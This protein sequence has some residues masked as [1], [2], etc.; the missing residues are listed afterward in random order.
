MKKENKNKYAYINTK[1]FAT[2]GSNMPKQLELEEKI[3]EGEKKEKIEKELGERI[4]KWYESYNNC[5]PWS[6]V[7]GFIVRELKTK[8]QEWRDKIEK[9]KQYVGRM[10][11][12][13][14][15]GWIKAL[16][17]LLK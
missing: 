8:D 4:R 12:E 15:K 6:A 13:Y 1:S 9:M 14:E 10:P 7:M 16:E 3:E 17:D 2:E 11:A 5:P